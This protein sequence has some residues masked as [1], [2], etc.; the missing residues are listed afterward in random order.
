[1]WLSSRI[2]V[3]GLALLLAGI[4][5]MGIAAAIREHLQD[6]WPSAARRRELAGVREERWLRQL[7]QLRRQREHEQQQK[8][9]EMRATASVETERAEQ[10]ERDARIRAGTEPGYATVRRWRVLAFFL[11]R[12][13][14]GLASARHDDGWLPLP[15]RDDRVKEV[16][17]HL[18]VGRW[19]SRHEA[20]LGL[21]EFD[22][23]DDVPLSWLEV[24]DAVETARDKELIEICNSGK[25]RLT[26]KGRRCLDEHGG[27]WRDMS[28]ENHS[29]NINSVHGQVQ[30]GPGATMHGDVHITRPMASPAELTE[31]AELAQFVLRL[32]RQESSNL[33]ERAQARVQRDADEVEEELQL[34]PGQRE[35]GR[36]RTALERITEALPGVTALTTATSDL[37]S[38]L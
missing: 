14:Q 29:V 24:E 15:S 21:L 23:L 25:L 22:P 37:I 26:T 11:R 32:T 38:R 19:R 1:M 10:A 18:N 12:I 36:V 5:V 17:E 7:R 27:D 31:V 33:P 20:P 9:L 35:T 8:L 34:P 2:I 28:N 13:D 16:R 3:P 6:R 30:T 4:T